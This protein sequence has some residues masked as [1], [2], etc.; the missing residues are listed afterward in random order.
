MREAK[1]WRLSLICPVCSQPTYVNSEAMDQNTCGPCSRV[2]GKRVETDA[3][4]GYQPY[5]GCEGGHR[6]RGQL[7]P[8]AG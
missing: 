6:C 3:I 8:I 5:A 1:G 7:V 2:D 4:G